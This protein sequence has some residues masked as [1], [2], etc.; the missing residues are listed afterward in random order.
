VAAV[1]E[2]VVTVLDRAFQEPLAAAV[3][4][5]EQVVLEYRAKEIAEALDI[6]TLHLMD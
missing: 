3:Q 6:L 2:V 5:L 1:A 4:T